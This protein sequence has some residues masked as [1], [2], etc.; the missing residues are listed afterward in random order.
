MNKLFAGAARVDISPE[1]GHNLD[2][3]I[4]RRPATRTVTPI[5]ARALALSL[6]SAQVVIFS[7][8][9][10]EM[11]G[12]LADRIKSRIEDICSI[13][14]DH[15]FIFPTHNHFGPSVSGTYANADD[16]TDQEAAYIESLPGLFAGAASE[17]VANLQPANMS[18]GYGEERTICHNSR[19]WRKDG[20]INWV[21]DRETLWAADSGPVNPRVSV[22]RFSDSM[23]QTIASIYN[24]SC[25]ANSSEDF[26]YSSIS[27]DWVGYA[28]QAIEHAFGGEALFLLAPCGNIH[29]VQEGVP[30]EMGESIAG[31]VQEIWSQLDRLTPDQMSIHRT[32]LQLEA[33]DFNQYDSGEIEEFCA[34]LWDDETILSVQNIFMDVLQQRR[35]SDTNNYEFVIEVIILGKLAIVC[36]PGEFFVELGLEIQRNSPFEH[37]LVVEAL[38]GSIGYIPTRKAY[39]EGGYQPSVG[40]RLVPGSGERIVE[41]ALILLDR[42]KQQVG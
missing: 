30:R 36:I 3:W 18:I 28:S 8:D 42:V 33:R 4:D 24:F 21:G 35:M 31:V 12:Q 5:L 32:I 26:E 13:P 23:D 7:C 16:I 19:F 20:A 15:I 22:L 1:I 25:H 10:L 9:L 14:V 2:G 17:A 37:T 34:Q 6:E 39:E 41:G 29:P 40:A 27:W 11:P 38:S